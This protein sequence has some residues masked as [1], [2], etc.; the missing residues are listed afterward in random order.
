MLW[1]ELRGRVSQESNE[2]KLISLMLALVFDYIAR[3]QD[4]NAVSIEDARF[5]FSIFDQPLIQALDIL[6]DADPGGNPH[7]ALLAISDAME[8][9]RRAV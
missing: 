1:K 9:W 7:A 2:K 8:K 3:H 5:L 6:C 4:A